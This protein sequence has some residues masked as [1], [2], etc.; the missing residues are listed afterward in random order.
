MRLALVVQ[1]YGLEIRGGAELHCRLIGEHL[2][3]RHQVEVVTTCAEDYLTWANAYPAGL[4]CVNDIPV[5]RFPVRRA[6]DLERFGRLQER[7]FFRAHE[8]REAHAWLDE[9]GPYS[10]AMRD[11]IGRYRESF[12]Y[13]ICFS[14]RYWTTYHAMSAAT[15]RAVLVPTAEPDPAID[16]PI[17]HP[18]FRGARAIVFN[19][20]EERDMIVEKSGAEGVAGD[21]VGVGI[22]EPPAA[23]ARS[24]GFRRNSDGARF[25]R[26]T[27]IDGP[28]ILYVGRIDANKGCRQLF[29]YHARAVERFVGRGA[30]PPL[31]VLAGQAVL[32][33]P[34]HPLIRH[35]GA[36]DEQQKFD[37]LA[38]ASLL[39]MPSFYESLSMVLLEA[40]AL[41][42][43]VLVNA[44]CA[45]LR[46]QVERSGGGLYYAD[47]EEFA[48]A[49]M[50]LL[51]DE[52]LRAACGD[53]GRRYFDDNYRWPVIEHKYERILEALAAEEGRP[54][55]DQATPAKTGDAVGVSDTGNR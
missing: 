30:S 19:S 14:Y 11:W 37:A 54:V 13:W 6:R 41:G 51:A 39:V 9:Q 34:D 2:A 33:I 50:L 4:D 27:G 53:G 31:L 44:H 20:H 1:R 35:L 24:P 40:W 17:F 28:F 15:G 47:G 26:A 22:L 48:A 7:V 38:A 46:G 25:R 45:V 42:R 43:P 23:G 10:P 29:D 55:P 5:W 36:I 8:E 3:A 32:E 16:L 18:V 49:L 52:R 12:D 21:V